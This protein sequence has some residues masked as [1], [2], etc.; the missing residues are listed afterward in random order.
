MGIDPKA[1]GFCGTC[2]HGRVMHR[3]GNDG[4]KCMRGE[5]GKDKVACDCTNWTDMFDTNDARFASAAQPAQ[6]AV[7]PTLLGVVTDASEDYA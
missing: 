7:Q 5:H 4:S 1:T 6:H 2:G 3:F